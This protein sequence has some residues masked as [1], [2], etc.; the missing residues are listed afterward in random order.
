MKRLLDRLFGRRR[1]A[2]VSVIGA[3]SPMS[4]APSRLSTTERLQ[5]V[6][7]TAVGEHDGKHLPI[8]A[9]IELSHGDLHLSG[10]RWVCSPAEFARR[11]QQGTGR[12]V[13]GARIL[14]A[15]TATDAP[16]EG[17]S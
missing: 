2:S 13:D 16:A 9:D 3:P 6:V 14:T 17:K 4:P 5:V 12:I 11:F 8:W 15:G 10:G 1:R 7:G